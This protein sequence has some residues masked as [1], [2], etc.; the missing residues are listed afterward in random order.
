MIVVLKLILMYMKKSYS[1]LKYF[2]FN[3]ILFLIGF[4]FINGIGYC[5]NNVPDLI[6]YK[7]D[8]SGTMVTNNAS[9]SVGDNPA[10]LIGGISQGTL[11]EF[12]GALIGTGNSGSVDYVNTGWDLNLGT[13]SWTISFW[14]KNIPVSSDLSYIFG[15]GSTGGGSASGGS[16]NIDDSFDTG[17]SPVSGGSSD[18]FRCFTNGVA[19]A[20]NW[21]LRGDDITDVLVT[22]GANMDPHVVHFVYDESLGNIKAYLDGTLNNTVEQGA[23]DISGTLP[24]IIGGQAGSNGLASGGLMDEFRIYGRALD[25][26][27]VAATWNADLGGTSTV[28]VSPWAVAVGLFLIGIV[29]IYRKRIKRIKTRTI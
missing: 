11:G 15:I 28:P 16:Y 8:E 12:G 23:L 26:T 18:D 6:Y 19:G 4:L 13:G 1:K 29:S 27:E 2:Q 17:G 22:G 24:F 3:K 10:T 25:A 20:N 14:T 5:Y 7:F 21:I 9:S